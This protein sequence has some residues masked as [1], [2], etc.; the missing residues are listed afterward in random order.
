VLVVQIDHVDLQPA[1][2]GVRAGAH[3]LRPSV[4][5][6]AVL[7]VGD[8]ELGGQLHLVAPAGDRLAH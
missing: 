6:L 1:Q 2:A 4:D 5:V 7:V 8:R 3:V